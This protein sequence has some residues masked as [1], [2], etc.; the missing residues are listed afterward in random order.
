M[1]REGRY[2][3]CV[4]GACFGVPG[5]LWAYA[6]PGGCLAVFDAAP[7]G[8]E[9]QKPEHIGVH[10]SYAV[11][12][13]GAKIHGVVQ[14]TGIG[15]EGPM[16]FDRPDPRTVCGD[17]VLFHSRGSDAASAYRGWGEARGAGSGTW[18][19]PRDHLPVRAGDGLHCF[20]NLID[21]KTINICSIYATQHVFTRRKV[22][23]CNSVGRLTVV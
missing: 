18:G 4:I 16:A 5:G 23:G 7:G 12:P 14:H 15:P 21:P 6:I 13:A 9:G 22:R 17:Q 3:R 1:D 20:L 10:G 19:Q 2:E 11:E 8:V